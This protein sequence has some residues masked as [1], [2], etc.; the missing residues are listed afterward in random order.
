MALNFSAL[1]PVG[2]VLG[3]GYY[4]RVLLAELD[5]SYASQA[6]PGAGASL[7]GKRLVAVKVVKSMAG[8]TGEGQASDKTTMQ[9]LLEARL[10]AVIRHPH[11]VQ[12]LGVCMAR[13][14]VQLVLEYC[15]WGDLR[16][17]L[18]DG[19]ARR[20]N[21]NALA[22]MADMATQVASAVAY[23]HSKLCLHRDLAARNVL[24][25]R[26]SESEAAPASG[27]LLKLSDLGLSRLLSADDDY[28]RVRV[29]VLRRDGG[30]SVLA[31]RGLLMSVTL[32]SLSRSV[33]SRAGRTPCRCDGSAR[34]LLRHGRT[35]PR[36]TCSALACACGRS[37][38]KAQCRTR[39]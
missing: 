28:Y 16:S 29:E 39:A 14:P 23:M 4:G 18:R 34:S 24:V 36:A 13:V 1:T 32:P 33:H 27:V 10:L 38:P 2:T 22:A 9:A 31:A 30:A 3:E 20:G 19:G 25:S 12:L 37:M 17:Y 5:M 6:R 11:L 26:P 21:G 8:V 35:R 15:E 7:P